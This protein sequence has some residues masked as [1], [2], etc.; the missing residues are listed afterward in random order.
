LALLGYAA[1]REAS[2][3]YFLALRRALE[4]ALAEGV[5]LVERQDV[6]IL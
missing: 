5:I 6:T 1:A 2:D 4:E 3:A